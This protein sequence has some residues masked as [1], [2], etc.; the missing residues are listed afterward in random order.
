MAQKLAITLNIFSQEPLSRQLYASL[1]AAIESGRIA[2]GE[3]LPSIRDMSKQLQIS[4]ITVREAM[5]KLIAQGLVTA[6]HGSGNYVTGVL[7]TRPDSGLAPGE[8][9]SFT[10]ATY[11]SADWQL[12]DKFCW[13]SEAAQINQA[14][15]NSAF[16][17][18][19]DL[20]VEY[21]FRVYQP[22]LDPAVGL[23]WDRIAERNAACD[24]L[25]DIDPIDPRGSF[26]LRHWLSRWLNGTTQLSTSAADIFLVCGAQQARDLAARVLIA[27]GSVVVVEEPGSITDQLAYASKGAKLIHIAQDQSGIRADLLP[28]TGEA[29]AAHLISQANFP[30]GASLSKERAQSILAWAKSHEITLVEDGYGIGFNYGQEAPTSLFACAAAAGDP[31]RV[32]YVGSLSQLLNPALRLGFLVLPKKFHNAFATASWLAQSTPSPLSQQLVLSYFHKGYFEEDILRV[33]QAARLRRQ[34]LLEGLAHW[35][36]DLVSFI[37]VTT[38]FHQ[39]IWFNQSVDDLRV[40][41]KALSSGIGVVPLSPYYH[42]AETRSGISLSF[43]QMN[44]TKIARGLAKLLPIVEGCKLSW[45][46]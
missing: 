25:P 33:T 38:G 12:S 34:A 37:P 15:N 20:L 30:T 40:F 28:N 41:E 19:W 9:L 16:H 26:E 3:K 35:P 36:C 31:E 18:W 2:S 14:F 6:R 44:E 32:I 42:G 39:T 10:Q 43:A 27:D 11:E 46:E 22:G 5:D 17:P 8:E 7:A 23:H 21:D 13:S 29:T 24:L 4:I 1:M 45:T